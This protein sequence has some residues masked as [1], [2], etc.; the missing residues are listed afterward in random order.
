MAMQRKLE[1]PGSRLLMSAQ[2]C[3]TALKEAMTVRCQ[4]YLML[5]EAKLCE[6]ALS[7]AACN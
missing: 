4:M 5:F 3:T 2:R 6:R 7:E 1:L